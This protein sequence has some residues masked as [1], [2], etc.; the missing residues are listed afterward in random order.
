MAQ[1]VVADE[2]YPGG[3]RPHAHR[4]RLGVRRPSIAF[5]AAWFFVGLGLLA[6][7][8]GLVN[9]RAFDQARR[10]NEILKLREK[11]LCGQV[12][13]LAGELKRMEDH[14]TGNRVEIDGELIVLETSASRRKVT[15]GTPQ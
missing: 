12:L 6:G 7:V 3:A 4:V 8:L 5:F 14:L 11:A 1:A 10:E 15:G 2:R 9:R 13:L